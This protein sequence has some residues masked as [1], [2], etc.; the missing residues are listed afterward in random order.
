M[1]SERHA[2]TMRDPQAVEERYEFLATMETSLAA[3]ALA[4]GRRRLSAAMIVVAWL[5]IVVFSA[6]A[7]ILRLGIPVALIGALGIALL[8]VFAFQIDPLVRWQLNRY[9]SSLIGSNVV[10]EVRPS[11]ITFLHGEMTIELSWTSITD[12]KANDKAVLFLKG[13]A[14]LAIMPASA[15]ESPASR[16]QF[17]SLVRARI[18]ASG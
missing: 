10:A 3:S 14:P 11:G 7:T 5:A 9:Y 4:S 2:D 12:I 13:R 18:H 16:D 17:I 8:A 15:F 1:S 6:F